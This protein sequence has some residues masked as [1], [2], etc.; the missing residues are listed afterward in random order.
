MKRTCMLSAK[1]HPATKALKIYHHTNCGAKV[2]FSSEV[3][4]IVIPNI[5]DKDT[6]I[7]WW[8]RMDINYFR[9]RKKQEEYMKDQVSSMI[10]VITNDISRRPLLASAL[11][12]GIPPK[13]KY[14]ACTHI[15]LEMA[16]VVLKLHFKQILIDGG[17]KDDHK[18]SEQMAKMFCPNACIVTVHTD[19]DNNIIGM[20]SVI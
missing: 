10:L 7:L 3:T 17:D 15:K 5:D 6:S 12:D 2:Q 1:D 16:L 4:V 8:S 19:C 9:Q 11:T 18:K 14:I 13:N 20:N